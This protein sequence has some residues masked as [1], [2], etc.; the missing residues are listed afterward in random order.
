MQIQPTQQMNF[1]GGFYVPKI[2]EPKK[3]Q[4]LSEI[5]SQ[6][7]RFLDFKRFKGRLF[8]VCTPEHDESVKQALCKVNLPYT[9]YPQLTPRTVDMTSENTINARIDSLPIQ[10]FEIPYLL[11]KIKIRGK[12]FHISEID[13]SMVLT[14]KHNGDVVEISPMDNKNTRYIKYFP[15]VSQTEDSAA[16]YYSVNN[17]EVTEYDTAND[18]ISM[19][20]RFNKT[21]IRTKKAE[22]KYLHAKK[23]SLLYNA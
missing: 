20:K 17:N 7:Q 23:M 8:M 18:I 13:G 3:S 11:K 19:L 9:Y 21:L 12:D 16:R 1:K 5:P 4:V 14:N 22:N 2:H 10:K 15:G 6:V